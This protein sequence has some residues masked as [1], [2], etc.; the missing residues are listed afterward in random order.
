[1]N[2]GEHLRDATAKRRAK[3]MC[4]F[5]AEMVE[6]GGD[7]I[8]PA[9]HRIDLLDAV[10]LTNAAQVESDDAIACAEAFDQAGEEHVG[11]P[12]AGNQYERHAIATAV[13]VEKT[14]AINFYVHDFSS[15]AHRGWYSKR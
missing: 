10:R 14:N 3:D 12:K 11:G 15:G 7:V 4:S 9:F 8:S 5:D 1:M 6:N 2:M 13:I